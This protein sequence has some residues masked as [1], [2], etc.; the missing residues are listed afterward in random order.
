MAATY[1]SAVY[2]PEVWAM[3]SLLV[4]QNEL[5]MGNLVHRDFENDV[6]RAGDVV[7][8]RK[9]ANFG[10]STLTAHTGTAAAANVTVQNALA[11]DVSITLNQHK[12]A[13]WIV[14]DADQA[15]SMHDLKMEYIQPALKPLAETVD[16]A[17]LTE[18]MTG[19]DYDGSTTVTAVA[20]ATVGE[21]AAC[22]EDDILAGMKAMNDNKCP[23]RDRYLVL[24]SDHHADLLSTTVFGQANTSGS[25]AGLREALVGRAFGFETYMSQ[26]VPTATDTGT[27]P[28]SVGFHRNAITFCQRP[29]GSIKP[30]TGAISYETSHEGFAVRVTESYESLYSGCVMK[31]E[32]LYGVQL[33]EAALAT[34]INP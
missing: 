33:L 30:G 15:A 8:T 2:P 34:I 23:L 24:S 4:L 31:I 27:T 17:I 3:E 5:V 16:L 1:V 20:G 7:H 25:T 6:K 11:T 26:Q 28:Q 18:L 10:V 9:P 29:L 13:A 32:I 21:N 12:Y 19:A 14:N 22:D